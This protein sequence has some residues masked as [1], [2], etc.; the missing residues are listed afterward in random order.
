MFEGTRKPSLEPQVS[1]VGPNKRYTCPAYRC[2][3]NIQSQI[4][5]LLVTCVNIYHPY[6]TVPS[7][8]CKYYAEKRI[9]QTGQAV[10]SL[11]TGLMAVTLRERESHKPPRPPISV[12]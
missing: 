1:T 6:S 2:E 12:L 8:S 9:L 11:E 4:R 7:R 3:R 10:E 5:M